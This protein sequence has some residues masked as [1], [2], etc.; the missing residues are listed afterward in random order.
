MLVL[1]AADLARRELAHEE[2]SAPGGTKWTL[3]RE[4]TEFE[5]GAFLAG[6]VGVVLGFAVLIF[7]LSRVRPK[8]PQ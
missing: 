2:I 6:A 8:R 5:E 4:P 1:F 3:L 7:D